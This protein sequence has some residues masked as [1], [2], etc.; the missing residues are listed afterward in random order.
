MESEVF[1]RSQ[2]AAAGLGWAISGAVVGVSA[3]A[4]IAVDVLIIISDIFSK[5]CMT[6]S[7]V[8]FHQEKNQH[9]IASTTVKGWSYASDCFKRAQD[10]LSHAYFG[11][12]PP[13]L[14]FYQK[15]RRTIG[16]S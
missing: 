10:S 16:L 6:L 12:P 4:L 8:Y 7:D 3:T 5:R 2:A 9:F 1:Y 11:P 13:A 15:I 14:S